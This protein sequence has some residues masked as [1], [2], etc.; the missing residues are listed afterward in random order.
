ML[1]LFAVN[2]CAAVAQQTLPAAVPQP[3]TTRELVEVRELSALTL[4]PD[5]QTALVRVDSRSLANNTT[6]LTWRLISL[7]TGEVRHL[8]D[9]G[10]PF[11]NVNGGLDTIAP[12]W[13]S[14]SAWVYYRG[15]RD[16]QAQVW[17]ISAD[18]KHREQVTSFDADVQ[19]FDLEP[20]G[21]LHVAIEGATR[22]EIVAAEQGEYER[23]VLV[24]STI[25][26]GYRVVQN[27]PVNGRMATYRNLPSLDGSWRRGT[28]LGDRPLRV[29]TRQQDGGAFG[30]AS[31]EDASGFA[32]WWVRGGF[33]P[34]DPAA[35]EPVRNPTGNATA[36]LEAAGASESEGVLQ[37]R[38]G[39]V[40]AWRDD[41]TGRHGIC[42]H[43]VCVEADRIALVGWT[44]DGQ[45]I[46]FQAVSFGTESLHIWDVSTDRE[47][48]V[49]EWPGV[50]GAH[51]SGVTGTCKLVP[52][53]RKPE[54]AICLASA[55]DRPPRVLGIDLQSGK[56]RTLFDPNPALSPDRLGVSEKISLRDRWGGTTY[57]YLV[58]PRE[59]LALPAGQRPR[60]P[61]VLTSY[62][63]GGFLLGG[64]GADVPEHVLAGQGYAAMCIDMSS[65]AVRQASGVNLSMGAT[66]VQQGMDFFED[67]AGT[68]SERGIVDSERV[69][70]SGF[71]ASASSVAYTLYNSSL[72]T[73][74]IVTTQSYIDPIN[75]YLAGTLG[76]CRRSFQ[77]MGYRPPYDSPNGYYGDVSPAW[78]AVKIRTPLLMQLP[79]VE[80]PAMMQLYTAMEDVGRVVEI[81]VFPDE[82]HMK[83]QPLHRLVVYDRNVAWIEFWLKGVERDDTED[84]A[85]LVRWRALRDRQCAIATSADVHGQAPWYCE[86]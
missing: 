83:R 46:A 58:L 3:V 86:S 8:G 15:L 10:E 21:T 20:S 76:G 81:H 67:A 6:E 75:C 7:A 5:G 66:G 49:F 9:A 31:A 63:C 22:A 41:T 77:R 44:S 84:D 34:F 27:F 24:D 52:G 30:P 39:R 80:Y 42:R 16:G 85:T 28:L 53:A 40:L 33:E 57:G 70:I 38:S 47:R 18:G 82:Y 78:N 29:V 50:L 11:W 74:A 60:L 73:A 65:W 61:L 13:S 69:V 25:I 71:S 43:A 56:S 51:V 35:L 37:T 62:S 55:A 64:S 12:Q 45:G 4:S 19:G 79:D 48:L 17:R 54:E 23:G 1:A 26:P 14:D 2:A 36:S 68:L 72:F 32:D 59:W